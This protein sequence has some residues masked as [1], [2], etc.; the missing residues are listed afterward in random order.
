MHKTIQFGE[1]VEGI[2]IPV[3]NE[4]EV[5]ASAGIL[6]LVLFYAI[7]EVHFERNFLLLKYF[8]IL[9]LTDFTIRI[10]INPKFSPSLILARL[11]VGRQ[12][13]EYVGAP[14]KKFAWKIGLGL[15]G[16]MFFLLIILNGHS[17]ISAVSCLVCLL[18]LFLESA[19]GICAGCL[20]YG[21]F[22]KEKAEYCPGEI[23]DV[24]E[25]QDIQK[26][27]RTQIIILLSFLVYV[28]LAILFLND[29]FRESPGSLWDI[30]S[31][32]GIS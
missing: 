1:N 12:K 24:T 8:I 7:M 31:H 25:R 4:R 13:P 20:L 28:L 26:T 27:S 14:Q 9:F 19:F 17:V 10:F 30:L 22:Y 21:W 16:A 6:F 32:A 23:C 11:L 15:A 5:R 18:F 29:A 3:L 2:K